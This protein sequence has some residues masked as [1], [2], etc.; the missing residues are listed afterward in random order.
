MKK[1]LLAIAAVASLGAAASAS[2]APYGYGPGPGDG[3]AIDQRIN[4]ISLRIDRGARD[5][6]LN[7]REARGLRY[8]LDGIRRLEVRYGRDG[9]NGRERAELNGRLDRLSYQVRGERHDGDRRW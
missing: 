4:Q 3:A 1:I 2:A 5:G 9:L 6:S 8:Q 7:F